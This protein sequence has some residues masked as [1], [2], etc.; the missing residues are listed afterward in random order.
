MP[1]QCHWW[2]YVTRAIVALAI[3]ASVATAATP[4]FS[5][6]AGSYTNGP[7]GNH[8]HHHAVVNHLLHHRRHD[9]DHRLDSLHHA[10]H[11]CRIRD[12]E[13]DRCVHGLCQ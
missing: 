11:C 13:G 5:P 1:A 2:R 10:D 6:V 7:D 9:A 4:T 12:S 8:Q 3:K